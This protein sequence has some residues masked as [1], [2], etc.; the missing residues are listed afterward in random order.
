MVSAVVLIIAY[1]LTHPSVCDKDGTV[2]IFCKVKAL[3]LSLSLSLSPSVYSARSKLLRTCARAL[4]R[5][6]AMA[7]R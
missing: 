3:S 5:S 2:S 6:Q 1:G 7:I 4:A